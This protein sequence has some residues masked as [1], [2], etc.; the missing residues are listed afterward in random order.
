MGIKDISKIC[1]VALIIFFQV[2]VKTY[3]VLLYPQMVAGILGMS[4]LGVML[5]FGVYLLEQTVNRHRR[6]DGKV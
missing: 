3:Q 5:Y 1:L 6:D 2:K 4:L